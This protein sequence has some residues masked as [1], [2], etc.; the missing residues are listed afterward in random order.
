MV[1]IEKTLSMVVNN[2]IDKVEAFNIKT[3]KLY[4]LLGYEIFFV[5][6]KYGDNKIINWKMK[7]VEK[8]FKNR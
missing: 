1:A 3:F 2:P 7:L 8:S 5:E 6:I 4:I